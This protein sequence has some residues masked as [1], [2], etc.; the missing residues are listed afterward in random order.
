M[1][2][3]AFVKSYGKDWERFEENLN[4]PKY[5]NPDE[6]ADLFTKLTNDLAYAQTRYPDSQTSKYLNALASKAHHAIYRNK[7]EKG[8]RFITFWRDELPLVLKES[9]KN[10]LYAFL[11]FTV[12]ASIGA[13][14]AAHDDTF[15]RL[16]LGD[17]YVNMT[18]NNIENGDPMAVY[19]SMRGSDMIAYITFNNIRVSFYAFIA[20]VIF[21]MGTGMLLFYNGVMLGSFQYFFFQKGLF[22]ESASAI[23]IHGTLEISAIIIAGGAGLTMGN[24]FLFPGTYS[25][26]AS[27]K[28]GAKQG[29]KI[30]VGLVPIFIVAGFLEAFVTRLTEI[31]WGFKLSIILTSLLFIIYYF[32]IYPIRKSNDIGEG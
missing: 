24:S 12:A 16:I 2:E 1:R 23:W 19:K 25:R 10:L 17:G 7:K 29:L 26:L 20:G 28:K 15:V 13:F 3:A 31:H 30:V 14:S 11:I 27:L 21:S 5:T 6:L 18:L 4:D 9:H 32:V 8:R 22:L